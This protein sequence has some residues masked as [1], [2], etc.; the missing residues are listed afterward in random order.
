MNDWWN[1]PPD[2]PDFP[3]CPECNSDDI[4]EDGPWL[5]CQTCGH[6]WEDEPE[7]E[8][9]PDLFVVEFELEPAEYPDKCP[10]GSKPGECE[11]CDVASDFAYDATREDRCFGRR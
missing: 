10:H 4:D 1:D 8:I 3:P 7:K 2:D 9:D 11:A 6:R 5:R